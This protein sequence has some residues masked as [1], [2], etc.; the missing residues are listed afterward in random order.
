MAVDN[1]KSKA[2]FNM[3]K[4]RVIKRMKTEEDRIMTD[5]ICLDVFGKK[6]GDLEWQ[7]GG[8]KIKK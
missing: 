8:R 6:I 5:N 3:I 4:N 7:I 2:E 1:S